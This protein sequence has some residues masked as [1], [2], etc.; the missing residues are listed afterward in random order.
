MGA[1]AGQQPLRRRDATAFV[2]AMKH[3]WSDQRLDEIVQVREREREG[4]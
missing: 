2:A 4:E 3:F 1:W